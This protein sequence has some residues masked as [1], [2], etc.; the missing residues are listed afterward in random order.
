VFR[1]R[2][3]FLLDTNSARVAPN[4]WGAKNGA[5]V[6]PILFLVKK[7]YSFV[8][9]KNPHHSAKITKKSQKT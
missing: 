1:L 4:F 3:N 9:H 6:A 5:R 7:L 8:Q 2:G